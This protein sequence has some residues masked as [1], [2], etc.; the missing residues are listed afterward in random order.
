MSVPSTSLPSF[1][2]A[3]SATENEIMKIA[4]WVK[5]GVHES[6]WV[7]GSKVAPAGKEDD[8]KVKVSSV[9]SS[10]AVIV[11]SSRLFSAT[12]SVEFVLVITGKR[13]TF[14]TETSI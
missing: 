2:E 5:S 3:L 7:S 10:V 1:E 4:A 11:N 9:S 6:T 12:C 14:E 13:F 8:E